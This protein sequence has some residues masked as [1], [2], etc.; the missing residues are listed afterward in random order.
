MKIL[1]F[2]LCILAAIILGTKTKINIGVFALLF[3]M[4]LNFV[5]FQ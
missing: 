1:I 5:F 3:A 2:I 4:V